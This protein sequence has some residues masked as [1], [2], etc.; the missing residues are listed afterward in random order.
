MNFLLL[1]YRVYEKKKNVFIIVNLPSLDIFCIKI[2][3]VMM[4][5]VMALL[6]LKEGPS[7]GQKVRTNPEQST[8]RS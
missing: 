2:V 8:K 7:E 5:C 4:V 3:W 1:L 6:G